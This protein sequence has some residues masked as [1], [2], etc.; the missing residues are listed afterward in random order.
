MQ[1]WMPSIPTNYRG[2]YLPY[3]WYVVNAGLLVSYL[4]RR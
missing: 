3:A 2:V 4:R 1:Q